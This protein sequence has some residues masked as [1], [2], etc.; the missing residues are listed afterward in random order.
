MK[1]N[2]AWAAGILIGLG[3]ILGLIGLV[4][5]LGGCTDLEKARFWGGTVNVSLQSNEKLMNITWKDDSLWILTR[6]KKSGEEPETYYF[7]EKTPN[8]SSEGTVIIKERG[9]R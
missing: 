4:A 8:G 1:Q 9:D 7:R 2:K 3:L 5:F 6:T